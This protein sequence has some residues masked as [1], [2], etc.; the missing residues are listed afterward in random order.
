M[1]GSKPC[2]SQAVLLGYMKRQGDPNTAGFDVAGV[3]VLLVVLS[4]ILDFQ[5]HFFA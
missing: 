1:S 3:P 5:F 2:C 4:L